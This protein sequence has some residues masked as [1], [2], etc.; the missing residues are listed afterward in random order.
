MFVSDDMP[1][2]T[3]IQISRREFMTGAVIYDHQCLLYQ[4]LIIYPKL[5]VAFPWVETSTGPGGFM[6]CLFII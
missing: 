4:G 6:I 2:S 5:F 1:D 3:D